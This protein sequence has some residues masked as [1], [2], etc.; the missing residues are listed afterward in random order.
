MEFDL[1]T[2]RG[3]LRLGHVVPGFLGLVVFWLPI[4]SRKGK[5]LHKSAGKVFEI[6][7]G[8]VLLSALA[9][10]VWMIVSPMSFDPSIGDRPSQEQYAISRR[11]LFMGCLLGS[12]A[13]YTL[14]PLVLSRYWL[15]AKKMPSVIRSPGLKTLVGF[16]LAVTLFLAAFSFYNAA[17][18]R[19]LWWLLFGLSIGGFLGWRKHW[20]DVS[21]PAKFKMQ[22][23]YRHMEY[24]LVTGIAFHTAFFVFGG[25]RIIGDIFIGRLSL[26]PWLAPTIIGVPATLIW[27]EYYKRKFKDNRSNRS[28]SVTPVQYQI[29]E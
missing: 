21:K 7:C 27:V 2:F 11:M 6:C 13:V 19:T 15:K 18:G 20:H 12:L 22:W 4:F 29:D 9:S 25:A 10:S 1:S 3:W 16:E 26:V 17:N 23:W 14:V 28:E 24:M 8:I 5:T